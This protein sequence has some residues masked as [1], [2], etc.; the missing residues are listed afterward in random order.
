[1]DMQAEIKWIQAE[2]N[3]VTDP[4][5]IEVFS[6]LLKNRKKSIDS[7]LETYNRELDEANAR[8]DSGKFITQEDLEREASGW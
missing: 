8:I 7:A 6:R 1:M 3:K 4:T 5:L 2:L